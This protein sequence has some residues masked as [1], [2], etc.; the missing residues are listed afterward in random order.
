[1]KPYYD[2]GRVTI[3]HGDA[4]ELAAL[5]VAVDLVLTDPPY[6]IGAGKG[7]W[8]A[9]AAVAIGLHHAARLVRKGGAMFVFT[10][11][12]GRGIEF[13][14]GAVGKALAFNRLLTWQKDGGTSR[15]AGPWF[16][17]AVAILAFGRATFGNGSAPSV[18]RTRSAEPC[19]SDHPAELPYGVAEWLYVPFVAASP[20][21]LDPFCGTGQLLLPAASRGHRVIGVEVEERWCEVAANR[22][23]QQALPLEVA[24]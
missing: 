16:W 3:Y 22:L 17:D 12:S 9:T 10:T 8:A 7:E 13:T 2:D 6:A 5:S 15:A 20:V 19:S 24:S 14:L 4:R 18:F 21:V 23:R 11:T 1:M